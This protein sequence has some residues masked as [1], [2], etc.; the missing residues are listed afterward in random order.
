M[1]CGASADGCS[2]LAIMND[3]VSTEDLDSPHK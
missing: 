1:G 3:S 2:V